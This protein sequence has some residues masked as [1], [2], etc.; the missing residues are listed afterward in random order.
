MPTPAEPR[1]EDDASGEAWFQ[2][3][4]TLL[5]GRKQE[6]GLEEKIRRMSVMHEWQFWIGMMWVLWLF[7]GTD[8]PIRFIATV[9]A[10]ISFACA[11][12]GAAAKRTQAMLEWIEYK[13]TKGKPSSTDSLPS[14]A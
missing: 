6:R 10:V 12:D 3:G 8:E 9:S 13:K 2:K 4:V 5:E 11:I 14:A 7:F 1:F